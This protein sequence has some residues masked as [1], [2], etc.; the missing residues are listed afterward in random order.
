MIKLVDG[1]EKALTASTKIGG[2]ALKAMS[3]FQTGARD[4]YWCAILRARHRVGARARVLWARANPRAG[5][6]TR[7]S[8]RCVTQS[9]K[10]STRKKVAQVAK[11]TKVKDGA[12]RVSQSPAPRCMCAGCDGERTHAQAYKLFKAS[13]KV[14]SEL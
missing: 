13:K 10:S 2:Y 8:G 6:R 7:T 11:W 5:M 14:E 12:K 1:T 4:R 9:A 3:K